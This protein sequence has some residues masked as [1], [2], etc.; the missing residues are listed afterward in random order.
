M[1]HF[2]KKYNHFTLIIIIAISIFLW[3]NNIV[4]PDNPN[5]ISNSMIP[6]SWLF[7]NNNIFLSESIAFILIVIQ[8]IYIAFLNKKYIFID[9]QTYLHILMFV[10]IISIYNNLQFLQPLIFANLFLLFAF[11]KL[12]NAYKKINAL[13]DYFEAALF[14]SI[15]S[16]FYLNFIFFIIIIWIA[17]IILTNF[18]IREWIVSILGLIAPHL[19]VLSFY[20]LFDKSLIYFNL[21]SINL[22]TPIISFKW[23]IFFIVIYL[24]IFILTIVSLFHLFTGRNIKKIKIRKYFH[25]F[26]WF[27]PVVFI[28]WLIRISALAELFFLLS[29][30][31]SFI[32]TGFF[33][34]IKNK[35]VSE[36]LF[37]V[38]IIFIFLIQIIK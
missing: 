8:A 12:F 33:L 34:S 27:I 3:F 19:V 6:L 18:N 13:A 20:F 1:L 4:I 37:I 26:T 16:L 28:L 22:F 36:I 9:N 15:G 14:I 10:F 11:N 17:M 38:L 21:L 23:N 32:L 31:I 2:F 35:W 30:P 25:I 29:F 7:N 24:F 5:L